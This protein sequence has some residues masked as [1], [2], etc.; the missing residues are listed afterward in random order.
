[1]KKVDLV[2]KIKET[3]QAWDI[4]LAKIS[5]ADMLLPSGKSGWTVTDTIAHI[6][7]FER[8]MVAV[9]EARALVGSDLWLLP[10]DERNAA[11]YEENH[12]RPL[13]A[14]LTESTQIQQQLVK[15][16]S[17]LP[18]NFPLDDP[19]QFENM[20]ADWIPWELIASN[21]FEH[22]QAHYLGLSS[23]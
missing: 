11:I 20:P 7:W 8:E 4:A 1:M 22:Y 19:A 17:D 9:V 18:H 6:S 3:H 13:T 14:I 21:S 15:A 12:T 16:L 23:Q 5:E 10:P 2:Q